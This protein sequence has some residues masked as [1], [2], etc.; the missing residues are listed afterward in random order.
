MF[1]NICSNSQ[2]RPLIEK[3]Y[4]LSKKK[5]GVSYDEIPT[6]LILIYCKQISLQSMS[7]IGC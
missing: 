6:K 5:N 4:E 2:C 3:T 1:V 7:T